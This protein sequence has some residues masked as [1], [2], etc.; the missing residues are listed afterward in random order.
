MSVTSKRENAI[1]AV[2]RNIPQII[3]TPAASRTDEPLT[4]RP[5]RE[6][7][8]SGETNATTQAKIPPITDEANAPQTI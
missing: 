2:P 1:A 6:L 3:P 8:N 5:K 7:T 4:S